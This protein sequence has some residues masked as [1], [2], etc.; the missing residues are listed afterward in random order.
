[1]DLFF[2]KENLSD[3]TSQLKDI[4]REPLTISSNNWRDILGYDEL[5]E[6]NRDSSLWN[7]I[8]RPW[9]SVM[10]SNITKLKEEPDP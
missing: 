2:V 4:E 10:A 6:N 9:S 5:F 8:Q 7:E 3:W 1:M